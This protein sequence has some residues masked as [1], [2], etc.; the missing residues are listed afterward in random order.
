[1]TFLC[2]TLLFERR[3]KCDFAII[4][5]VLFDNFLEDFVSLYLRLSSRFGDFCEEIMTAVI[6]SYFSSTPYKNVTDKD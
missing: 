1:M 3:K 6:Q 4:K 5:G 2:W